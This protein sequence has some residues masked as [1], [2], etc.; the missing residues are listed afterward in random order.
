[1]TDLW[2][3]SLALFAVLGAPGPTNTLLA[4]AGATA[5]VRRTLPLL[6]AELAGYAISIAL[7]RAVLGPILAATPVILVV[8]KVVVAAYLVWIAIDVWRRTLR[9]EGSK[10]IGWPQVFTATLL[11]PKAVILALTVFPQ[12]PLAPPMHVAIFAVAV[13]ATGLVWIALGRTLT[14]TAGEHGARIIPRVA[15][16]ALGG[17]AGL[18]LYSAFG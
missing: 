18:I 3:F 13:V 10:A 5:G 16:V 8:L 2:L 7:I 15:A 1:M 11:N 17:F 9:L 4:T 12:E 14:A 6:V